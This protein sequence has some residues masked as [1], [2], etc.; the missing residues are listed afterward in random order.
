[1]TLGIIGSQFIV[2]IPEVSHSPLPLD[3]FKALRFS[4]PVSHRLHI[5][6][7]RDAHLPGW[8]S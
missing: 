1:M 4:L 2:A 3:W 6:V 8:L 5:A 7:Q